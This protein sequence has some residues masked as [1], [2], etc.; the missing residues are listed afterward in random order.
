[1]PVLRLETVGSP[2]A[3]SP[4]LAGFH[5]TDNPKVADPFLMFDNLSCP[6]HKTTA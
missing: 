5:R 6:H 2:P 3:L 1:M 4:S